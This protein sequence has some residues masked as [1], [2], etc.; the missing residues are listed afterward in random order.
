MANLKSAIKRV[1]TNQKKRDHN[2]FFKTNMRSKIK[3]VEELIEANDLENA[4][5]AYYEAVKAIDKTIQKGAI[6]RNTG[7]RQKSRLAKL[8]RT[9]A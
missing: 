4:K 1:E 3:T 6:H 7:N 9:E 5:T 8:L 2:R